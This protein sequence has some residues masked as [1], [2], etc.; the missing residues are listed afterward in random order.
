MDLSDLRTQCDRIHDA[1]YEM[2]MLVGMSSSVTPR[3]YRTMLGEVDNA[4]LRVYQFR[5][6]L[7]AE[8]RAH[9]RGERS[10]LG[11]MMNKEVV[12]DG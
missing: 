3:E 2:E 11:V 1:V 9:A 6:R 5:K 4:S 7:L 12:D 10:A 8:A